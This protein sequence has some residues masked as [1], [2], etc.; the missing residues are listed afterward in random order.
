MVRVH[1]TPNLIL[2][3]H[4]DTHLPTYQTHSCKARILPHLPYPLRIQTI[5]TL[6][7]CFLILLILSASLLYSTTAFAEE[8]EGEQHGYIRYGLGYS[9][10]NGEETN[11]TGLERFI[12]GLVW[13]YRIELSADSW[14]DGH[15]LS[16]YFAKET[17]GATDLQLYWSHPLFTIEWDRGIPVDFPQL[18]LAFK[19]N[20]IDGVTFQTIGNNLTLFRGRENRIPQTQVFDRLAPNQTMFMLIDP[21]TA[22]DILEHSEQVFLNGTRLQRER[23]YKLNYLSG[24]LDILVSLDF[25]M[26]LEVKYFFIPTISDEDPPQGEIIDGVYFGHEWGEN[27]LG[28]FYFRRGGS[29]H[30]VGGVSGQ[31]GTGPFHLTGEWA[32][33]KTSSDLQGAFDLTGDFVTDPFTLHYQRSEVAPGFREIG[34][35]GYTQGR[36]EQLKTICALDEEVELQLEVTRHLQREDDAETIDQHTKGTLI[37]ALAPHQSL[38]LIYDH[39]GWKNQEQ[40]GESTSDI[41]VGYTYQGEQLKMSIGQSLQTSEQRFFDLTFQKQGIQLMS[42]YHVETLRD[43]KEHQATVDLAYRPLEGL[44]LMGYGEY[45]Q[46]FDA[47]KGNVRLHLNSNWMPSPEWTLGGEYIFFNQAKYDSTTEH[48][49]GRADY[50]T[51]N[52]QVNLNTTNSHRETPSVKT[53]DLDLIGAFRYTWDE[54]YNMTYQG[55]VKYFHEYMK[56]EQ[57]SNEIALHQSHLAGISYHWNEFQHVQLSLGYQKDARAIQDTWGEELM[58]TA[59]AGWQYEQDPSHRLSL[60]AWLEKK[61]D[62]LT[63]NLQ[64][65]LSYPLGPVNVT[66]AAQYSYCSTTQTVNRALF[67]LALSLQPVQKITPSIAYKS[68]YI[69]KETQPQRTESFSCLFKYHWREKQNFFLELESERLTYDPHDPSNHE[70]LR[71]FLGTEISY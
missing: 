37:G 67:D 57:C 15:E 43:G 61:A 27:H 63:W 24:K 1:F 31:W 42:N 45:L 68:D 34:V 32:L 17:G 46:R 18:N 55:N 5:P 21:P 51:S 20:Q 53:D 64:N 10:V 7:I 52:Y 66:Q 4:K 26:V 30:Q 6:L 58:Y 49:I 60:E 38:L 50:T 62:Q 25:G 11:T 54:G 56:E 12:P 36:S 35:N 2:H 28:A 65:R 14:R 33:S 29:S 70:A 47:D 39:Q 69:I 71:L 44:D 3:V 16:Y 40:T 48:Y 19:K 8:S 23:D 9:W 13:D 22:G 59:T 41:A